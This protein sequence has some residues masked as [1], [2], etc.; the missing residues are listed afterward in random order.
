MRWI[1]FVLSTWWTMLVSRNRMWKWENGWKREG[2]GWGFG[3]IC[4]EE[5]RFG[6]R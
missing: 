2:W 6:E 5:R 4:R 1:E 3:G